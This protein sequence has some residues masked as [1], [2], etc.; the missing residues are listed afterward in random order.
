VL[1]GALQMIMAALPQNEITPDKRTGTYLPVGIGKV[2]VRGK[3]DGSQ[4]F[5]S[6]AVVERSSETVSNDG[7]SEIP[8]TIEASVTLLDENA[9][10][11]VEIQ[12]LQIQHIKGGQSKI[13]DWLF[14]IQWQ[15][16]AETDQ[17]HSQDGLAE[18]R[19]LILADRQGVGEQLAEQLRA[20]K[21]ETVLVYAGERYEQ[22]SATVY[23]IDPLAGEDI[24]RVLQ[25]V[26]ATEL[27]VVHLWSLD[28]CSAACGS[29][30]ELLKW[31][32]RSCGSVLH[33]VQ[34]LGRSESAAEQRLWV[35]TRGAQAISEGGEMEAGQAAVWGLGRVVGHE[36]PQQW[37]GLIDLDGDS[38]AAE[39]AA[40]IVKELSG[41]SEEVRESEVGYRG[42]ER[43]VPRLVRA[44]TAE[45]ATAAGPL[46]LSA[47]GSYLITGG[48]GGL[49]LEVGKWLVSQGARHVVLLGRSAAKESATEA[50]ETMRAAGAT[51][52]CVQANVA[53]TSR[54]R[55]VLEGIEQAGKE[56]R[57]VIHAAGVLDDGVLSAQTW[58]RFERV[59]S[60]KV[61]GGW[62]LAELTRGQELDFFVLFSS[63]ASVLGSPGQ[64]NYAAANAYLDGL[65]AARQR[66]GEVGLSINWGAWGEVGL[67]TRED[68]ARYVASR[69]M[70]SMKPADA[71]MALGQA[72]D[73]RRQGQIAL[74]AAD[75]AQFLAHFP[76]GA[77][78]RILLEIAKDKPNEERIRQAQQFRR[79]LEA[80]PPGKR[81]DLMLTHLRSLVVQV[82]GFE[83]SHVIDV[84]RG[85]FEMGMDSL[86]IVDL[87]NRIQ[88]SLGL[89]VPSTV[90]FDYATTDALAEYLTNQ[91]LKTHSNG[92][93]TTTEAVAVADESNQIT[94]LLNEMKGLSN[95]ELLRLLDH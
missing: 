52:E 42:G 93:E 44:R 53:D 4:T 71:L 39:S 20:A 62:N 86:M 83:P 60:A 76:G 45:A 77:T 64:G 38:S 24:G 63:A 19:Y 22:K 69:G 78:P 68:R 79:Q 17:E 18:A 32:Q 73:Q 1:D 70:Q 65:A 14:K 26:G 23:E 9:R 29:A 7:P 16:I 75:W 10:P 90:I 8:S 50:I 6:H 37:G 31:Q 85:F 74:M 88:F 66:R 55:E 61:L 82:M 43:Y 12:G 57:G 54:M 92:D 49:G 36:Q 40:Q 25:A 34:A 3:I 41:Q 95:D 2:I 47:T 87:K 59:M 91:L 94:K 84:R 11:I 67:A 58:E 89:T 13:D 51:I 35:V 33:L 56:L 80:A 21:L 46:Q 27:R 30:A 48:L 28:V 72:L 5:W 15:P 81:K